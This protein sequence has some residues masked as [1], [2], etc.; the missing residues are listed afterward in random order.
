MCAVATY[1]SG[2]K[3]LIFACSYEK[4][5]PITGTLLCWG[6]T[7]SSLEAPV[8]SFKEVGLVYDT[9]FPSH[10]RRRVG[11]SLG[12]VLFRKSNHALFPPELT[13]MTVIGGVLEERMIAIHRKYYA[14]LRAKK[15][16]L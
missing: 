1:W 10:P 8:S 16:K 11:P 15:A 7:A 9:D 4:L 14:E 13:R 5:D 6:K 3:T 12:D 2:I